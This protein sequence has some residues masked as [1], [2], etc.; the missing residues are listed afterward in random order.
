[1]LGDIDEEID[2]YISTPGGRFWFVDSSEE[3][4]AQICGEHCL[5]SDP[6]YRPEIDYDVAE[7][8]TLKELM[9]FGF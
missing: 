8:Y 4:A 5:T 2:G 9:K 6:R 7:T 3:L 1:M